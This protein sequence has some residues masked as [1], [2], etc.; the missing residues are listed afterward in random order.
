MIAFL[1]SPAAAY[2]T[3]TTVMVDGGATARCYAFPRDHG[4]DA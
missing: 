4:D 2:V 1:L 3:G